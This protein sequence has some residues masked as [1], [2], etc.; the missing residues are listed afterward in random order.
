MRNLLMAAA[1]ASLA[2][3]ASAD[4][5]T[6]SG[7][8]LASFFVGEGFNHLNILQVE[9]TNDASFLY[10]SITV[11]EDLDAV[12][13]GKYNIGINTGV[14]AGSST[15]A[16]GRNITWGNGITHFVGSWA[17]DGGS[18]VGGELHAFD[19]S[20]WGMLDATYGAGVDIIGDD[21]GHAAGV[22]S[23]AISLAALGL[24]VGDTFGFDV[25]STGGGFDPGVDHLSLA[26][27]ATDGW[28]T[29][30]T[31]GAFLSYTVV[32]TPSSMALLGLGGLVAGRRRR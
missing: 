5:Y 22:Q 26:G 25:V 31:S 30:S 9:I 2:G 27:E 32:P 10:V 29:G 18:G 7:S 3:A 28:G 21:S 1:I 11:D 17:D 15:D 24:G 14:N 20:A 23:Y 16:W 8:D 4:V 19:G 6:D 12:S 13:W